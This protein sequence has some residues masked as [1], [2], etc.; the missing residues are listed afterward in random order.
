MIYTIEQIK[1]LVEP[2]AKKYKLKTLWVFGSY[3]RG[4]A[5]EDSDIDF[6]MDYTDSTIESLYDFIGLNDELED[7]LKKDIDLI[8]TEALFHRHMQKRSPLFVKLVSQDR[9]KLYESKRYQPNTPRN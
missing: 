5:T 3:A 9:I 2:T 7:L 6:L 1:E 8:S 4:E